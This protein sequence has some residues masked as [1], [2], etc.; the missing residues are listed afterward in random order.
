MA[1]VLGCSGVALLIVRLTTWVVIV[2]K[3]V[4]RAFRVFFTF[5][6]VYR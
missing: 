3:A 6:R 2:A 1:M 5:F 4:V